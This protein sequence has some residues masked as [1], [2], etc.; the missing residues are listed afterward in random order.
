LLRK[1]LL[2]RIAITVRDQNTPKRMRLCMRD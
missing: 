1:L 2:T